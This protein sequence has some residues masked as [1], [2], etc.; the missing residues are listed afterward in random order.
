MWKVMTDCIQKLAIGVLGTTR[1]GGHKMEGA[2]WWNEEIKEKV[3]EKKE[4]F[5]VS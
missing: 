2:R 3:R 4:A 1:R 5:T